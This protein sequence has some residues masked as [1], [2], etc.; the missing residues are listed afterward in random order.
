MSKSRQNLLKMM[1]TVLKLQPSLA[2]IF[3]PRWYVCT[4]RVYVLLCCSCC[5]CSC[6]HITQNTALLSNFTMLSAYCTIACTLAMQP[7]LAALP[8][9]PCPAVRPISTGFDARAR[10]LRSH[11]TVPPCFHYVSTNC[12]RALLSSRQVQTCS[13]VLM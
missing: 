12:M 11:R 2:S 4:T 8:R 5:S 10:W 9:Q 1:N 6:G 7:C 3:Y 13:V